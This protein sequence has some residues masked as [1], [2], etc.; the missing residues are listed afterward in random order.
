MLQWPKFPRQPVLYSRDEQKA[1][2]KNGEEWIPE[3]LPNLRQKQRE[4]MEF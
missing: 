4:F 3:K 1:Y 2:Y